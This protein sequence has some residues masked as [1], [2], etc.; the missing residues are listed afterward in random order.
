METICCIL[1]AGYSHA[2]GV[3]LT[4]ELFSTRNVAISSDAANRRFQT[5]WRDH[6]AWLYENPSRN[7]EEYLADLLKHRQSVNWSLNK[8][9]VLGHN[10]SR[11]SE[12]TEAQCATLSFL[13]LPVPT[14][15][16]PPFEWA[17]E[18]IGAALATPLSSDTTTIN[19][20][21]GARVT[22]PLHCT[23]HSA[24]WR[25]ITGKAS[26][27]AAVTTNYDILIERGLRHKRM[28]RVFGP[29][30]YYGG[31]PK[32]Q[33]LRGTFLPWADYGSRLE[34]EGAIP[35]YKLHGSLN[36]SRAGEG[37]ELF[38]DLRPAFRGGGDAAIIP[39]V[40]EKEIPL[41]LRPVWDSA[42]EELGRATVWIICGYSLPAYDTAIVD[43]LRR[44]AKAG[45]LRRILVLDPHAPEIS[46][47]YSAIVQNVQMVPL[48]GLPDG[49]KELGQFL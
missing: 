42:E 36:W 46:C 31:I 4:R 29:G 30:F 22:F 12:A 13:D 28:R 8:G 35:I 15:A 17:V 43:L 6:E 14:R 5:V 37:L 32:P 9:Y 3:P 27:V 26:H 48:D 33:F 34:L 41:W 11:T 7:P 39:P 38:Q 45:N 19:F 18:L 10:P 40:P 16:V 49:I 2:A 1:G 21:Y 44:A 25:E 23:S 24:F 20:R 47:R